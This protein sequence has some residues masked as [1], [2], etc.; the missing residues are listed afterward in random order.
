MT[1][2][3]FAA[4]TIYACIW[5]YTLLRLMDD[6]GCV[7]K[8]IS[9]WEQMRPHFACISC[10]ELQR[11]FPVTHLEY[12]VYRRRHVL[13]GN[14]MRTY[15]NNASEQ[16]AASNMTLYGYM[17][18]VSENQSLF[19]SQSQSCANTCEINSLIESL[20]RTHYMLLFLCVLSV[21]H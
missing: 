21:S 18:W 5:M 17:E 4:I 14:K 8:N 1:T 11:M 16:Q 2:C 9:V 10:R 6:G 7:R 3:I 15:N 19:T 12:S 13:V 20:T